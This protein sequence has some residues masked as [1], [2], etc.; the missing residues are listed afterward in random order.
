MSKFFYCCDVG[1]TYVDHP[2]GN[3]THAKAGS[4]AELLFLLLTGV[5][6]VG[7]T[8]KPS[9][10]VVGGLLGKLAPF[11]RGTVDEGRGRH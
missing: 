8:V 4:M 9:F 5:R 11:A 10:E 3:L 6:M 7:V 1:S 2:I